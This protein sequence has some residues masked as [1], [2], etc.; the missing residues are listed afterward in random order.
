VGY[1]GNQ[2]TSLLRFLE[3]GMVP[4]HNNA[5]E[6]AIRP[7][8]VGRRNWLFAG[9]PRGGAAA[10]TVYTS[11]LQTFAASMRVVRV[12]ELASGSTLRC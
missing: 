11:T 10:A 8:A 4:I 5:C 7:V 2:W 9:S 1:V 3:D 12:A 6:A